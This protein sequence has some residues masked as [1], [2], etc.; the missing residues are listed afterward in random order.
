MHFAAMALLHPLSAVSF[1]RPVMELA[2]GAFLGIGAAAI[3][4]VSRWVVRS[5]REAR[6][7]EAAGM[8]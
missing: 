1:A 4:I 3:I 8:Q 5:S 2:L 6:T 7:P